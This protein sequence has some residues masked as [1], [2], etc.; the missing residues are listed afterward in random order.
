MTAP[1]F[2]SLPL[3][4]PVR[5]LVPVCGTFRPLCSSRAGWKSLA[6]AGPDS[7]GVT[8]KDAVPKG[9]A[10]ATRGSQV[11]GEAWV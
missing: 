10:D 2:A 1:A 9:A 6:Q 8:Q 7:K 5:G 11:C 3:A 4:V